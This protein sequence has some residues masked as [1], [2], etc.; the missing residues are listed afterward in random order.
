MRL[1]TWL[2]RRTPRWVESELISLDG[3]RIYTVRDRPGE[4]RQVQDKYGRWH[5]V[6]L[7]KFSSIPMWEDFHR[8][9]FMTAKLLER[10]RIS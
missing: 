8:E 1:L 3:K 2:L 7:A 9:R 5:P 6:S 4:E 10:S